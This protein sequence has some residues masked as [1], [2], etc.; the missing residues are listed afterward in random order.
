MLVLLPLLW[1]LAV[2][3]RPSH[4]PRHGTQDASIVGLAVAS[5]GTLHPGVDGGLVEAGGT[6]LRTNGHRL[7]SGGL[8][9]L[10]A[11]LTRPRKT[12]HRDLMNEEEA[13]IAR[14]VG[15]LMIGM[16][17]VVAGVMFL[18]NYP[19]PQIQNYTYKLISLSFSIFGAVMLEKLQV[20]YMKTKLVMPTMNTWTDG[21]DTTKYKMASHF[22][23]GTLFLCWFAAL[24]R[25]C[26]AF[27][28][29]KENSV[30]VKS[31][32]AHEAAFV[33]IHTVAYIQKDFAKGVSL[34]DDKM[35]DY[36]DYANY[37]GA[38]FVFWAFCKVLRCL[39]SRYR[40]YLGGEHEGGHAADS[41]DDHGGEDEHSEPDSAEHGMV[42]RD[43]MFEPSVHWSH[44][45]VEGEVDCVALVMSFLIRQGLL[46]F[47]TGRIPSSSGDSNFHSW[48]DFSWLGLGILIS[49]FL[50]WATQKRHKSGDHHDGG[51][52]LLEQTLRFDQMLAC[53]CL[54]WFVLTFVSWVAMALL[55]HQAMW[56][57]GT[58]CFATP[59]A[60]F[61]L[62]VSDWL[63]D[64]ELLDE[65]I[66]HCVINC[67]GFLIGFAWEISFAFAVDSVSKHKSVNLH[68]LWD[69]LLC[70]VLLLT[71]L[72]AW[73]YFLLPQ[74]MAKAPERTFHKVKRASL[75]IASSAKRGSIS[76]EM[77]GKKPTFLEEDHFE[78]SS[79]ITTKSGKTIDLRS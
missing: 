33:A 71:I 23:S 75:G 20:S 49:L 77:V 79:I 19:D 64:R 1:T 47:V 35:D 41:H 73:R 42:P 40:N 65:E 74:A 57:I 53:M 11:S 38:P 18:L 12:G 50:I 29:S 72:P 51:E 2:A 59:L 48:Q 21:K 36:V 66:G 14:V 62:I 22:L 78:E 58:A 28:D 69:I 9:Q 46:F 31:F 17:L 26:Y 70:V 8:I 56:P 10:D 43:S 68:G 6:P 13:E 34:N 24:S 3:S 5:D 52:G 4:G 76:G 15:I 61:M 7:D 39:L 55:K 37:A 60:C 45:A 25:G 30:A 54:G 44:N 27:K 67:A 63:V 16:I 32:F